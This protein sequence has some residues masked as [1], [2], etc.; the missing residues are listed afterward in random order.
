MMAGSRGT[1]VIS[2]SQ[3]ETDGIAA[4]PLD[5]LN[6]GASWRWTGAP[7]RVDGPQ[8]VLVLEGAE[9]AAE[10]RK[11][12]ARMVRRLVGASLGQQRL[13]EDRDA[14]AAPV[15]DEPEQGFIVTDGHHS[16]AVTLIDV[17]DTGA[18]LVMFV[19]DLPPAGRDM[20]VVRV[21]ID[22]THKGAGARHAGG[23]ICF[24]P[25]TR[26][27]TPEGPRL[28]QHLRPGD[29][30]LT[31]DNGPQPILW[32]GHRRM[33]GARLYAMPHLRPIRFRAGALGSGRPEDD[34]LVSPQHRM[35][36]QG[37]AARALFNEAEVLVAAEDLLNDRSIVVDHALREVTYVHILLERHNIVFANGMETESFHPS[38]TALDTITPDQR[39]GLIEVL[40]GIEVNPDRYG[41]YARRNLSASEAAILRH[42]MAA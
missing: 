35:L 1:F 6:V 17:P 31:R 15:E 40:P 3:T 18:R 34:L 5:V 2:W 7:V 24:T 12:A 28:I 9:G 4:A 25:D 10:V 14:M 41:D 20:W 22:R 32:T 37:P 8:T 38:N 26:I 11:R 30:I 36:V 42:D 19:G 29:S 21:A 27:A 33:T 13:P 39:A 23:V 16:Y